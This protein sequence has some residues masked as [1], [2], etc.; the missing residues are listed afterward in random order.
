MKTQERK[1]GDLKQGEKPFM[2]DKNNFSETNLWFIKKKNKSRPL[3]VF[4]LKSR[5]REDRKPVF[6]L[7]NGAGE[8]IISEK[9][10]AEMRRNRKIEIIKAMINAAEKERQEIGREL[11][12]N[13]NQLLFCAL[14]KLSRLKKGIT[15]R[16]AIDEADE[17][18]KKAIAEIKS[19]S[20]SLVP[21][22]ENDQGL[23][24]ALRYLVN[25][26]SGTGKTVVEARLQDLDEKNLP[27][28]LKLNLYRIVQEQF[29]NIMKHAGASSVLLCLSQENNMLELVVKDDGKGF[30]ISALKQSK[31][32]GWSNIQ[33]RVSFLKGKLDINSQPGKGTSVLIELN[34]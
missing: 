11:H 4:P 14:L 18:I 32:I 1:P 31:G 5:Y 6:S 9:Q 13:V 15:D 8:K 12:D 26:Y 17:L 7:L 28:M 16:Q 23:V 20:H 22:I 33:S 34:S 21:P 27:E 29:N 19:L 25:F 24:E 10:E 30:D 3:M 2:P